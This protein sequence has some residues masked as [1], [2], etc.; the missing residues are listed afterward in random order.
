MGVSPFSPGKNDN[1]L[2]NTHMERPGFLSVAWSLLLW[3]FDS[4]TLGE[5]VSR[6]RRVL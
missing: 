5:D 4:L 1:E 6:V 3:Y 2:A